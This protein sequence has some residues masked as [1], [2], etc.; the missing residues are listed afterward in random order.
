MTKPHQ[1]NHKKFWLAGF[2]N[3]MLVFGFEPF[4]CISFRLET[5]FIQYLLNKISKKKFGP[6]H[7]L[8]LI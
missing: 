4:C 2:F 8:R 5:S 7:F 3:T 1:N 6:Q